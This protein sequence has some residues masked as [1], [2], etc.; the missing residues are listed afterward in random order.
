MPTTDHSEAA[1]WPHLDTEQRQTLERL[2]GHPLPHNLKWPKVIALLQALGDVVVESKDRYRVTID[3]NTEVFRPPHRGD[4][5]SEAVMKLRHFLSLSAPARSANPDE[6]APRPPREML[7]LLDYHSATVYE[8]EPHEARQERLR[9]YDPHGR[10]RQLHH[11]KGHDQGR[12][13]PDERPYFQAVTE[14][15]ASADIVVVFGH[16]DGAASAVA[17]L[18]EHV[19]ARHS[20]HP[21]LLMEVRL[22][23]GSYSE[24]QLLA[25]AHSL[26]AS[27]TRP[28]SQL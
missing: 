9:P 22:D 10:L 13:M 7:V 17:Q 23:A 26:A 27:S 2:L 12:R 19:R 24:A 3:G 28:T 14:A 8:L 20:N 21:E 15:I 25:A 4:L 11:V 5:S 18:E 16:G 1:P 6:P